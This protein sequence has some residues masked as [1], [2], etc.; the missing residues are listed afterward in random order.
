MFCEDGCSTCLFL[1]ESW[2]TWSFQTFK[3]TSSQQLQETLWQELVNIGAKVNSGNSEEF[4][5]H[6][7]E[8]YHF[9][10]LFVEDKLR[11]EGIKGSNFDSHQDQERVVRFCIDDQG[12]SASLSWEE[13]KLFAIRILGEL[14]L[15][16]L[17]HGYLSR[18][19]IEVYRIVR[20]LKS[21]QSYSH[22]PVGRNCETRC[23]VWDWMISDPE[24]I[25]RYSCYVLNRLSFIISH[26]MECD[27][28]MALLS[29]LK[30]ETDFV[31]PFQP[32]YN[33]FVG[34]ES[35]T[36]LQKLVSEDSETI[37]SSGMLSSN[38]YS[39]RPKFINLEQ[40]WDR[41]IYCFRKWN[42]EIRDGNAGILDVCVI[43]SIFEELLPDNI[44]A[45]TKR[46]LY[47]LFRECIHGEEQTL[48]NIQKL[49]IA[50]SLERVHH[51]QSRMN[52]SSIN[53][54]RPWQDRFEQ[55]HSYLFR[56][57]ERFFMEMIEMAD[58]SRWNNC[59]I[60]LLHLM[61]EKIIQH[62]DQLTT[63]EGSQECNVF[64][65]E[66]CIVDC[67]LYGRLATKILAVLLTLTGPHEIR[68][69][70]HHR[71]LGT[72][73][74]SY[75]HKKNSFQRKAT[76][77]TTFQRI[78]LE[79]THDEAD[80]L[81]YSLRNLH[82]DK[83][84][85]SAKHT[86][87]SKLNSIASNYWLL[88]TNS[89]TYL[90]SAMELLP[91]RFSYALSLF[92][93][94]TPYL[95]IAS[96]DDIIS[97]SPWFIQCIEWIKRLRDDFYACFLTKKMQ[98]W[99]QSVD[100]HGWIL[101][102][103]VIEEQIPLSGIS[104][105]W[106][107]SGYSIPF[108]FPYIEEWLFG[109]SIHYI[110]LHKSWWLDK[111][112][113]WHCLPHM[114][115][116][117]HLL[118]NWD[119]VQEDLHGKS[120]NNH[121]MVRVTGRKIQPSPAVVSPK[122]IGRDCAENDRQH[123]KTCLP[124]NRYAEQLEP[125][126]QLIQMVLEKKLYHLLEYLEKSQWV[127]KGSWWESTRSSWTKAYQVCLSMYMSKVRDLLRNLDVPLDAIYRAADET[128]CRTIKPWLKK[129]DNSPLEILQW[130]KENSENNLYLMQNNRK[131][132][133]SH[134]EQEVNSLSETKEENNHI[135][136]Y[137]QLIE[138]NPIATR[139]ESFLLQQLQWI[140]DMDTETYQK[141]GI[142]QL[143]QR[144]LQWISVLLESCSQVEGDQTSFPKL[145]EWLW[146]HLSY[147]TIHPMVQSSLALAISKTK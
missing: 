54:R 91:K 109:N 65:E 64:Y 134:K 31:Y 119:E 47:M 46:W 13:Y 114:K 108:T 17:H 62:V 101:M 16:L 147:D 42:G 125:I 127:S 35:T 2:D 72:P 38:H 15:C 84:N 122:S 63:H 112:L 93:L 60:Q 82:F 120:V 86:W 73:K 138:E 50:T 141:L 142:Y 116:L 70:S 36:L 30:T 92:M 129:Q 29:F 10:L 99:N 113:F 98:E 14:H 136:V 67:V 132:I 40:N 37:Y 131:E 81:S 75:G 18:W 144:W 96:V 26:G 71:T 68:N 58:S 94:W 41:M 32:V 106:K 48:A 56:G 107:P 133:S 9:Y 105:W 34:K 28:S 143:E 139:L 121:A 77:T 4:V 115:Q 61:I 124:Y 76:E 3:D 78:S 102:L 27:L 69:S 104:S 12:N 100:I 90:Q 85:L 135:Q 25:R 23:N 45:F 33:H 7:A 118:H 55:D 19:L 117:H 49:G 87:S 6:L 83:E 146:K 111:R 22:N 130:I 59:L 74:R 5:L 95:A 137:Q 44:E 11:K 43:R 66:Q 53:Q 89:L 140:T 88:Y 145:T 103:T 79:T 57:R 110:N 52:P 126:Q 51:L 97:Q 80:S 128:Y 39:H 20:I 24:M 123:S 1:R 21:I 8:K